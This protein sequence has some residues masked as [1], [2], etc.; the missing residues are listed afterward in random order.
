MST[1]NIIF[2]VVFSILLTVDIVGNTLVILVILKYRAMKTAMNYLLLN[3]AVADIIVGIFIAPELIF[4]HLF[5][6]PTGTTG[7]VLCK[8]VT[9][10]NVSWVTSLVS[11]F[12]LVS[13]A[14]ERFYT[15]VPSTSIRHKITKRKIKK[16]VPVLWVLAPVLT[17]PS[18]ATKSFNAE[19]KLCRVDFAAK[20]Q[21][22]I[23]WFMWLVSAG[24]VPVSMMA[25]LYARVIHSLW[26][27][28]NGDAT[29]IAVIN[30]RKRITKKSITV[31]VIYALCVVPTHIFYF[32]SI[33]YPDVFIYGD[34][35]FK[36]SYCLLMLNSLVNPFV[37]TFQCRN[38]RKY[39]KRLL[40]LPTR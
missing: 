23:Y 13:V 7:D 20:W 15:V 36:T 37:Y 3:L 14:V 31:S 40:R 30:A 34:V 8:T 35:F 1:D 4:I 32:F 2:C 39:L 22:V 17:T 27:K 12:T 16:I 26:L 29:H 6:H 5:K 19:F 21:Y 11:G 18:F 10:M 25:V 28:N 38:F 24:I 9:G 33:F